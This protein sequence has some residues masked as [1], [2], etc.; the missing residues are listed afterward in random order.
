MALEIEALATSA[1][2]AFASDLGFY[3]GV[4]E[5]DSLPLGYKLLNAALEPASAQIPAENSHFPKQAQRKPSSTLKE[6]L[7]LCP[8]TLLMGPLNTEDTST[9]K[10]QAQTWED[11]T[12]LLLDRRAS[13]DDLLICPGS[14]FI[15]LLLDEKPA[16][17]DLWASAACSHICTIGERIDL[18]LHAIQGALSRIGGAEELAVDVESAGLD[19]VPEIAA[20]LRSVFGVER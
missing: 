4:L 17:L 3:R 18:L 19:S 20:R 7:E 1:A 15:L 5:I 13:T 10:T 2:L 9:I 11:G 12:E 16:P 14:E 6:R 8:P